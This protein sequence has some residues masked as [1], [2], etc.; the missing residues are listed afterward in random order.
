MELEL[1]SKEPRK[2]IVGIDLRTVPRVKG[3][4]ALCWEYE[5]REVAVVIVWNARSRVGND[6]TRISVL[7]PVDPYF[8]LLGPLKIFK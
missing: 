7:Y 8:S 4:K 6:G 3:N 5:A 1:L 2:G